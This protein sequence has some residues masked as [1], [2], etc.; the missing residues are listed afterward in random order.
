MCQDIFREY[1]FKRSKN[2]YWRV[3]NDVFQS[4]CLN[5]FRGGRGFEVEFGIIPLCCAIETEQLSSLSGNYQLSVLSQNRLRQSISNLNRANQSATMRVF[6]GYEVNTIEGIADCMNL[7]QTCMKED[8][9]AFFERSTECSSAYREVTLFEAS[10]LPQSELDLL[11]DNT[12]YFM[13]LKMESYSLAAQY[14]EQ[15]KAQNL[16][17]YHSNLELAQ[18][19]QHP[20]SSSI[21]LLSNEYSARIKSDIASLEEQIEHLKSN[22]KQWIF[23][24]ISTNERKSRIALGLEKE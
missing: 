4:F 3:V 8:L 6:F 22:D 2:N 10:Y 7:L 15:I 21:Y 9:L 20:T 11:T 23:Q 5:Q 16:N 24:F 17:A 1:G 14:L 19:I 13:L 12:K 18:S